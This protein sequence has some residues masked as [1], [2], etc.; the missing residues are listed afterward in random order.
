[1]EKLHDKKN[2]T[3][4]ISTLSFA[5]VGRKFDWN[6]RFTFKMEKTITKKVGKSPSFLSG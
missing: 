6:K 5:R 3:K 1:L 2:I 4:K